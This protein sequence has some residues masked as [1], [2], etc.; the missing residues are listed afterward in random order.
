MKPKHTLYTLEKLKKKSELALKD[1][2]LVEIART[3]SPIL[4]K[5]SSLTW[6][7]NQ[8]FVYAIGQTNDLKKSK[9]LAL[10][11]RFLAMI[12]RDYP[13]E[14]KKLVIEKPE[15]P[16]KEIPKPP[17]K[18]RF[19]EEFAEFLIEILRK[20]GLTIHKSETCRHCTLLE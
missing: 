12:R 15:E 18:K 10:S 13:E 7:Y 20:R 16:K 14:F 2:E 4:E 8:A 9:E 19:E 6:V 11:T 5:D 1:L 17:E 3:A